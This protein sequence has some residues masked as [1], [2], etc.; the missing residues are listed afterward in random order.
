MEFHGNLPKIEL[1]AITVRT[2]MLVLVLFL[3]SCSISG[4]GAYDSTPKKPVFHKIKKGE[5]LLAI[6]S[7][8]L[9]TP[10]E[11]LLLNGLQGDKFLRVGQKLLVA[12]QYEDEDENLNSNANFGVRQASIRQSSNIPSQNNS[13][14][15]KPSMFSGGVLGWPLAKASR[16]VSGFGPRSGT[17]HDGLDLASP[18]GTTV[19]AAQDGIVAYSG[20]DLGGYGNLLVIKGRDN[21]ITVYA[22]NRSLDVSRGESVKKGQKIAEV[23]ETGKAE[24]PH[25][26]FEVR[27]KDKRGRAV[28]V[29]PLPLLKPSED[30]PRYRV[31]DSLEPLLAW[32]R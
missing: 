23:G 16:I 8:F 25:L 6:S 7:R 32:L 28:A 30:K 17:F 12:Y 20:S 31:N 9:T 26:H 19:L 11:I 27:A 21:L 18:S 10:D 3:T 29:D 24:G 14:S 1:L 15:D 2:V 4:F 13:Y 22:H 5:S